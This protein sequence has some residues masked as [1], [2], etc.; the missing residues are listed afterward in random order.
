MPRKNAPQLLACGYKYCFSCDEAKPTADFYRASAKPDGL[1]SQCKPCH[2]KTAADV[3]QR[4]ALLEAAFRR[5]QERGGL[6]MID[7]VGLDATI[8]G[9]AA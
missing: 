4:K 6:C 5:S 7:L 9:I 1:T 8:E 2:R 3:R